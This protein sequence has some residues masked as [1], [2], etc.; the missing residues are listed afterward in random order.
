MERTSPS[1]SFDPSAPLSILQ[2]T[3]RH[4]RER[5]LVPPI[6]WTDRHLELLRCSFGD[7]SF[8]SSTVTPPVLP[9]K[10]GVR[11][12]RRAFEQYRW[13]LPSRDNGICCLLVLDGHFR[14]RENLRFFFNRRHV[15]TLQ[16]N[17]FFEAEHDPG[18]LP[19]IIAA[20]ADHERI[21][22]LRKDLLRPP[23]RVPWRASSSALFTLK[24]RKITPKDCLHDPYIV[25]LLIAVAQENRLRAGIETEP[26]S[27]VF[28]PQVLVSSR[29]KEYMHLYRAR[30]SSS[31]LRSLDDPAV[32][33]SEP[34][35]ISVQITTVPYK[36]YQSLL[37]RLTALLLPEENVERMRERGAVDS[38]PAHA[39]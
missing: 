6:R 33:P 30:I 28:Q 31:F 18:A 32:A 11:C 10:Q 22:D 17:V 8:A 7:P 29:D 36:P 14:D 12:M 25:A 37:G 34:I 5:L 23:I 19:P 24:L 21:D 3:R 15:Q 4:C 13:E 9:G 16:C 39:I 35:A 27:S 20:Y 1:P 38:A 2:L 26:D